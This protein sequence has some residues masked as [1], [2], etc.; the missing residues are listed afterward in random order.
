MGWGY[1]RGCFVGKLVGIAVI[2]YCFYCKIECADYILLFEY[3]YIGL[4]TGENLRYER[5]YCEHKG[6]HSWS[7]NGGWKAKLLNIVGNKWK[8]RLIK[9]KRKIFG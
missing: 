2:S 5:T 4:T 9:L 1:R 8:T 7:E 3:I 6:L